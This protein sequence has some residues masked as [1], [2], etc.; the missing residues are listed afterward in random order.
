MS[1]NGLVMLP[2]GQVS[3][4]PDQMLKAISDT[5]TVQFAANQS[6]KSIT[7][8]VDISGSV[9]IGSISIADVALAANSRLASVGSIDPFDLS[10]GFSRHLRSVTAAVQVL[11]T[12]AENVNGLIIRG[13][14]A[15]GSGL[16]TVNGV[17]VASV[18]DVAVDAIVACSSN[19]IVGS[20]TTAL[21]SGIDQNT[22]VKVPAGKGVYFQAWSSGEQAVI[23]QGEFL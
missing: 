12:P 14:H 15:G 19:L 13:A 22:G 16:I 1:G 7:D 18:V 21:R 11:I 5:L 23:V 17:A 20:N 9:D 10:T 6:I 8:P 4:A 2:G 3:L